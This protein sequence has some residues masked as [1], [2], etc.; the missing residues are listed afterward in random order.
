MRPRLALSILPAG[1]DL[2]IGWR[3]QEQRE[4]LRQVPTSGPTFNFG[5]N[6][7]IMQIAGPSATQVAIRADELST[8]RRGELI[9]GLIEIV[10]ALVP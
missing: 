4:G 2:Y 9:N 1:A 3:R 6:A 8:D 10:P 5:P 7:G